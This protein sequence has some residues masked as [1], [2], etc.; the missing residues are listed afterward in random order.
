MAAEVTTQ[1]AVFR[2]TFGGSP[3]GSAV[4]PPLRKATWT[5]GASDG[6]AVGKVAEYLTEKSNLF[7]INILSAKG[8]GR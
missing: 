7:S 1:M 8:C 6:S 3:S 5:L 2:L 4:E